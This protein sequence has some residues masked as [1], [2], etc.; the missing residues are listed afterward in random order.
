MADTQVQVEN[1]PEIDS[2]ILSDY[3]ETREFLL[4]AISLDRQV[5]VVDVETD[6]VQE[7]TANLYGMGLCFADHQAFYIVWRNQDGSPV[8]S[9]EELYLVTNYLNILFVRHKLVGHNI[10]YDCLVIQNNLGIVLTPFVYSDTILQKHLL[11]EEPPFA[12]KEIAVLYL[13]TWADK[14][15][16]R[17]FESIKRNGGR[18]TKEHMEM[19]KA[20]TQVLAEYCCWD[21]I[22]TMKLFNLFEPQLHAQGLA[23]LFYRDEIMPLYREVVIPMKEKGFRI[24]LEHFARLKGAIE[25]EITAIENSLYEEIAPLVLEY[26][27]DLLYEMF[28][29]KKT[30]TFPKALAQ[31]IGLDLRGK[32]GNVTLARTFI[33]H[34]IV[35]T[36]EQR[37][38]VNWLL[39]DDFQFPESLI[40]YIDE[41][42]YSMFQEKTNGTRVFNL[43]SLDDLRILFFSILGLEPKAKT[44]KGA[45]KLDADSLEDYSKEHP[46]A[47]KL[48]EMKQLQKLLSTYIDGI[49]DRAVEDRIYASFLLFGTTSG[50]FSS[51]NP[52]LQN[53]VRVKDEDSGISPLVLKY[54]NEIKRGFIPEKGH[55]LVNADYSQLE[56]CAF[57]AASGDKKLIQVFLD[58]QD[59]YCA[60]AIEAEGLS[61]Y[62]A[63]KKSPQYLKKFKPELRQTYKTVALAVVYGAEAGRIAKLLDI[64]Y[65][66]AQ[67]II[68]RYLGAYPGL[69]SYIHKQE[70][71]AV[72]HGYVKTQFGRIRHLPEAKSIYEKFN[73]RLMDRRWA[74][75]HGL[76]DL[77]YKFKNNLN[78]AKNMP[79]QGLASHAVNRAMLAIARRFKAEGIEAWIVAQV[80]DEIT[81]TCKEDQAQQA[82]AIVKDCMENTTKIGVPLVAEPLLGHNWA[83]AKAA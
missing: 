48:V 21:V 18:T 55:V 33:E 23:D 29:I 64:T 30:G 44:E 77:R 32:N 25:T 15:Q 11:A 10:I 12:L 3:T 62:S 83:E 76:E 37:N 19:F 65:A 24:D 41:V 49:L 45:P 72:L 66:Q 40:P 1:A 17:L 80:H 4:W 27:Y 42:T 81:I 14:A 13:G 73:W 82:V 63:D 58:K 59:L 57:A 26:E 16:E 6:S 60:I 35:E 68:D 75:Q 36:E 46:F 47:A 56:P 51:R 70:T 8:F 79:I 38:F 7:K 34:L 28:P 69:K 43:N 50:R 9:E 54:A 52:N 78:N 61:Q 22:L 31:I 71:Q 2:V 53:Q 67:T 74:K 39:T 5:L 20:D